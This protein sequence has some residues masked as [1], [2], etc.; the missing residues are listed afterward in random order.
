MDNKYL[1]GY[2]ELKKYREG[3]NFYSKE[4]IRPHKIITYGVATA[5]II[6]TT[7]FGLHEIIDLNSVNASIESININK[8]ISGSMVACIDLGWFAIAKTHVDTMRYV[9]NKCSFEE[10]YPNVDMDISDDDLENV[11]KYDNEN[12]YKKA[13]DDNNKIDENYINMS[14]REK[15]NYLQEQKKFWKAVSIIEDYNENN[16]MKI[17]SK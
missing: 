2:K 12:K 15:I 16:K 9:L 17:I 7:A 6:G 11:L 4:D 13:L 10:K 5:V 3:K 14:T 8:F 1:K